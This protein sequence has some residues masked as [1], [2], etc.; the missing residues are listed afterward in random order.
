[1]KNGKLHKHP[2]PF[3]CAVVREGELLYGFIP[4]GCDLC[5]QCFKEKEPVE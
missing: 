3:G 1:M 2:V 5:E 4:K